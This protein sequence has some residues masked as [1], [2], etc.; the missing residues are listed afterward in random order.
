MKTIGLPA[1]MSS[2]LILTPSEALILLLNHFFSHFSFLK[3]STYWWVTVSS[4]QNKNPT[5]YSKYKFHPFDCEY[6]FWF[7]MKQL[8]AR[9]QRLIK[10]ICF[11]NKEERTKLEDIIKNKK[12]NPHRLRHL[13][14]TNDSD[15]LPEYALEKKCG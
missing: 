1:P 4:H 12:F 7:V 8:K 6:K 15:Y 13:S 9:I 3:I 5:S 10:T 14:I 11:Q 2:I